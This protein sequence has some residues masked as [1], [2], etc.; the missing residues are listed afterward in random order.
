[1]R[2]DCPFESAR[3]VGGSVNRSWAPRQANASWCEHEASQCDCGG[4]GSSVSSFYLIPAGAHLAAFQQKHIGSH[5]ST[6]PYLPLRHL[7][8]MHCQR[9]AE[10]TAELNQHARASTAPGAPGLLPVSRGCVPAPFSA[11]LCPSCPFQRAWHR[12]LHSEDL[13]V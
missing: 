11:C 3:D 2:F 1:M 7:P 8:S 5:N 12:P 9:G 6:C 10:G 4:I 13:G